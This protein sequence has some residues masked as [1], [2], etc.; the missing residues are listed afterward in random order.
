M[1]TIHNKFSG[2]WETQI[3]KINNTKKSPGNKISLELLNSI[4]INNWPDLLYGK[5]GFNDD[6]EHRNNVG[7]YII[8]N[9]DK[10]LHDPL[11]YCI[12]QVISRGNIDKKW[13]LNLFPYFITVKRKKTL[14]NERMFSWLTYYR[15]ITDKLSLSMDNL[16]TDDQNVLFSMII[17]SLVINDG[18]VNPQW[19]I[20]CVKSRFNDSYEYPTGACYIINPFKKTSSSTVILLSYITSSLIRIWKHFCD[21]NLLGIAGDDDS[22]KRLI[23]DNVLSFLIDKNNKYVAITGFEE[24]IE[25][26][27]S[28]LWLELMGYTVHYCRGD[29]NTTGLTP[30][31]TFRLFTRSGL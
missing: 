5:N 30:S 11:F 20:E 19:L 25:A 14:I 10:K 21:S 27:E 3:N 18:V 1:N 13:D 8:N 26:C 22:V 6:D 17:L 15:S 28:G 12:S 2:D 9:V 23:Y 31:Q 24:L 4:L 7:N 29:I 16:T